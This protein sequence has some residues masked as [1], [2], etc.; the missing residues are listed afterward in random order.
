MLPA[1][2]LALTIPGAPAGVGLVQF[3][4]K[5]T[6]DTTFAQLP[7]VAD[8]AEQVA[9]ASIVIH[10]SQFVPEAIAGVISFMIEGLSTKDI[11]AG[12]N[13]AGEETAAGT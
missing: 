11:S 12:T 13:L 10:L 4:I 6:M 3:S 8:F 1:M 7:V 9:A 2:A 5:L